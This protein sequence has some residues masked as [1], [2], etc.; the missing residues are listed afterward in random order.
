M[1]L[2]C[3]TPAVRFS[4]LGLGLLWLFAWIAD[5]NIARAGSTGTVAEM[6]CRIVENASRSSHVSVALLTRLVWQESRFRVDATS[7]AGAQGIA[8]FM[9]ETAAERGLLDPFDPEQ[10]IPKAAKLLADLEQR[11]GNIGLATAAYNAGPARIADWLG[12][13]ASLPAQTR[14]YVFIITGRTD[15]DWAASARETKTGAGAPDDAQSC[16]DITAALQAAERS[17]RSLIAPWG[18]QL[19]GNFTKAIALA[20]FERARRRYYR[21]LGDLQPM[22][23]GTILRSRGTRPYY[24]VLVPASSRAE[25]DQV[26]RA[27]MA[28]GGACVALR[29]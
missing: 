14:A 17:D 1:V 8:Q 22:I 7:S 19:A 25:A 24:R 15:E 13:S 3:V 11:F 4:L 20:S 27:I 23:I 28:G 12:G 16:I 18:I 2:R 29:T 10:A 26:C 21:V 6:T 5:A 9:P